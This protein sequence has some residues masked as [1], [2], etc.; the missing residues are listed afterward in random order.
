MQ[1]VQLGET[2]QWCQNSLLVYLC[3][4]SLQSTLQKSCV[5]MLCSWKRLPKQIFGCQSWLM[6][7]QNWSEFEWK[8]QVNVK[9]IENWLHIT[10]LINHTTW[11]V[12]ADAPRHGL[13]LS[14]QKNASCTMN[15]FARA[16]NQTKPNRPVCKPTILKLITFCKLLAQFLVHLSIILYCTSDR[17]TVSEDKSRFCMLY[18]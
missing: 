10:L 15:T 17:R 11:N 14:T 16:T 13:K 12:Y 4:N 7:L 1:W 8:Q 18:L 9:F 3:L 2:F 6:L 5:R